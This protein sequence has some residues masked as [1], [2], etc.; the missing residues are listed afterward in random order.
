MYWLAI[1]QSQFL[2]IARGHCIRCIT[3]KSGWWE[4]LGRRS[5]IEKHAGY[6]TLQPVVM[7]YVIDQLIEQVCEEI[8][9]K[10]VLERTN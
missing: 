1:D 3:T 8:A 4:S 2:S 7:E 9:T 5:L 6:F 10:D